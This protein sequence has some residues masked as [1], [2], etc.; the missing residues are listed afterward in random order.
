MRIVVANPRSYTYLDRR[1]YLPAEG[2]AATVSDKPSSGLAEAFVETTDQDLD[3]RAPNAAELASCPAYNEYCWGLDANP[4]L[5]AP[6]VADRLA[7]LL[8]DDH[9]AGGAAEGDDAAA[10]A[11]AATATAAFARYAARDVVYLAGERDV[12]PLGEQLCAEDGHQGPTR[13]ERSARFHAAL[14]VRGAEVART[15]PRGGAD[16]ERF[17]ARWEAPGDARGRVH[18]RRVVGDVGHDHALIFQSAQGREAMFG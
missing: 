15:C 11:A 6:Y 18:A 3:F 12:T 7:R 10:A 4:D 17:C 5:P 16:G 1:R 2:N 13:R 9:A 14:Q 8:L